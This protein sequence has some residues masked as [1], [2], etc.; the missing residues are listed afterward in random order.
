MGKETGSVHLMASTETVVMGIRTEFVSRFPSCLP[1]QRQTLN[2]KVR[3]LSNPKCTLLLWP[4]SKT[5]A[6]H[7]LELVCT[8]Q[9]A[10]H[11]SSSHR[12]NNKRQERKHR[13]GI[14]GKVAM[15]RACVCF[16]LQTSAMFWR[17]TRAKGRWYKGQS[18]IPKQ[19]RS[20]QSHTSALVPWWAGGLI[21]S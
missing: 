7:E 19:R 14:L 21:I 4:S 9:A 15:G 2:P 1:G 5:Q 20:T 11:F 6:L 10:G 16:T 17:L 12:I 13:R 18:G 8:A 3:T